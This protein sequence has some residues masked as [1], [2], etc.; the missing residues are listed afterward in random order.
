[1]LDETGTLGGVARRQ[2]TY[3]PAS[4]ADP[5]RGADRNPTRAA[6]VGTA[7]TGPQPKRPSSKSSALRIREAADADNRR[8]AAPA[9]VKAPGGR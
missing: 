1:M 5:I 9:A 8:L 7:M 2:P 4:M 6:S 3:S